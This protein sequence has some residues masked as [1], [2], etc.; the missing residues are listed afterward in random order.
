MLQRNLL[1]RGL[2]LFVLS[3]VFASSNAGVNTFTPLGPDGGSIVKV[4]FHPTN[5]SIA[6]AASSNN[7]YR[8]TDGGVTWTA[9]P[10]SH[11]DFIRDFAVDPNDGDR[12][13]VGTL[14]TI[15]SVSTD[16]G[17]TCKGMAGIPPSPDPN[18]ASSLEVSRD[19]TLYAVAQG[20]LLRTTGKGTWEKRSLPA[21]AV[22]VLRVDPLD[23]NA[24]FAHTDQGGFRSNDGGVSWQPVT[25]P[26]YTNDLAIPAQ[27]PQKIF[28]ATGNGMMVSIDGGAIWSPLGPNDVTVTFGLDPTNSQ[29]YYAAAY[30]TGLFRSGNQ[31]G[32]WESIQ[33][34]ARMGFVRS[35]AV[36]P[37][38]PNVVLIGGSEGIVRSTNSGGE[39]N[40]VNTGIVATLVEK[41][42]P[43]PASQRIYFQ[44]N[45]SGIFA[46]DHGATWAHTVNP[47]GLGS[48]INSRELL[49]FSMTAA[50]ESADQVFAGTNQGFARSKDGGEHWEWVSAPIGAI[51]HISVSSKDQDQILLAGPSGISRSVDGG[52]NWSAVAGLPASAVITTFA[53]APTCACTVF[54]GAYR[55]SNGSTGS[56]I[57]LGVYKSTDGGA[58]WALLAGSTSLGYVT[59]I[60]VDP[61]TDRTIY[62]RTE[63]GLFKTVDG[64][65]SWAT[66][67]VGLPYVGDVSIDASRPDTIYVGAN[68]RLA[69]S[70]DAGLT[71]QTIYIPQ[72][73]NEGIGGVLADPFRAH[74]VIASRGSGGVAELTVATDLVV[75]VSVPSVPPEGRQVLTYSVR[76]LGPVH[77]TDLR[78]VIQLPSSAS[79]ISASANG[80]SCKV[81]SVTVTCTKPVLL[82]SDTTSITVNADISE[83]S[84]SEIVATTQSSE[85]DPEASNNT[86]HTVVVGPTSDLSVTAAAP[87]SITEG[88][89]LIYSFLVANAGPQSA[90]GATATIQLGSGLAAASAASTRGT[91]TMNSSVVTCAMGDIPSNANATLTIAISSPTR[92]T[93]TTNVSVHSDVGDKIPSND[94][95]VVTTTVNPISSG[96]VGS[97]GT[98]TPSPAGS[99]GNGGAK[100]GGGGGGS[101]SWWFVAALFAMAIQQKRLRVKGSCRHSRRET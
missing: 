26:A 8:S 100:S 38:T 55:L 68:S 33:N 72:Q 21:Q 25:L 56:P 50:G 31:G 92:G 54:A 20:S 96:S 34:D 86:A 6:Y 82:A 60:Q 23:S 59:S 16:G 77:A 65:D 42:V 75:Q 44:T 27:T 11:G 89:D 78:T 41:M 70:V 85:F 1:A 47:Q 15:V 57:P 63:D 2:A 45:S 3:F 12:I 10:C 83:K 7:L 9:S 39:W 14:E 95:A 53:R 35:I 87:A 98:G 32:T 30:Y 64:G 97:N 19:G 43:A 91:C 79:E 84:A 62:A 24:L 22:F 66:L 4:A 36:N 18:P 58:N 73:T 46:L 93:Y 88:S 5:P 74:T 71:W 37:I 90:S 52:A 69:R 49:F 99:S 40:S 48:A 29:T 13:F 81:E 67:N 76:N 61:R 94:S 80:G 101:N 17:V 28:A 51:D